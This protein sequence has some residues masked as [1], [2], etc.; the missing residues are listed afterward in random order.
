M[1]TATSPPLAL[2]DQDRQ[3]LARVE[4]A[5][6]TVKA[7]DADSSLLAECR[8]QIPISEINSTQADD[9]DVLYTGNALFLKRLTRYFKDHVMKW[10]NNPP[11][12]KCGSDKTESRNTRGPE[13][14]EERQGGA[15]RVESTYTDSRFADQAALLRLGLPSE[16]FAY[17]DLIL[18]E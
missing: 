12:I 15:S 2:D 10:V 5:I 3:F 1:A 18:S 13:T 11:C 4:S 16:L 14:D 17:F 9:D 7:W 8:A 6:K